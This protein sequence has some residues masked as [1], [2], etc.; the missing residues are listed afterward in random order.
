MAE[1]DHPGVA[2]GSHPTAKR[3]WLRTTRRELLVP[4][5]YA[6][7]NALRDLVAWLGD[8]L[9]PTDTLHDASAR[10]RTL[11]AL[12][13]APGTLRF[14]DQEVV[15]TIDLALPPKNHQR[16]AEALVALDARG[17][18]FTDGERRVRFRLAPRVTREQLHGE[19]A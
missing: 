4:L 17:L 11:L 9:S 5:R 3:A 1:T 15:V 7:D 12:V 19:V 16:L 6:A 8:G 2:D 13:R 14:E 10:A 18:R